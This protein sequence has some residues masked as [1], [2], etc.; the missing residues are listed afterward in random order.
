MEDRARKEKELELLLLEKE[1]RT[2]Q[3][4]PQN[5]PED[6]DFWQQPQ[7]Q[8][9]QSVGSKLW[10]GAAS[11]LFGVPEKFMQQL[12]G[13]SHLPSELKGFVEQEPS[14]FA[15]NLLSGGAKAGRAAANIPP[16]IL[17]FFGYPGLF[18]RAPEFDIDETL[19]LSNNQSGDSLTQG[20]TEKLPSAVGAYFGAIPYALTEA[21]QAIGNKENPLTAALTAGL[22]RFAG[23]TIKDTP[24]YIESLSQRKTAKKASKIVN[25]TAQYFDKGYNDI[26]TNPSL[27]EKVSLNNID[28][29]WV[30]R[31][32]AGAPGF[33][34]NVEQAI[35]TGKLPEIHKAATDLGQYI[36]EVKG[37]KTKASPRTQ[38]TAQYAERIKQQLEKTLNKSLDMAEPGLKN[39]YRALDRDF[40]RRG[41]PLTQDIK[42]GSS[43]FQEGRIGADDLLRRLRAPRGGELFRSTYGQDLPGIE[44]AIHPEAYN[45]IPGMRG[46]VNFLKKGVVK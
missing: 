46:I 8:Q 26:L 40:I 18:P 41:V 13:L 44:R 27:P 38:E 39:R 25:D 34:T 9:D 43:L 21:A 23:K 28:P 10:D 14:R 36:R 42:T 33:S 1:R 2:R 6:S 31:F 5:Q 4:S 45:N 19:G 32:R 12:Q 7:A 20:L 3:D 22:E 11:G 37:R 16:N 17:E 29:D 30:S 35:S 24:K 15:K